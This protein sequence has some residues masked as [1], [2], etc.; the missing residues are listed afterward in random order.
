MTTILGIDP[1]AR[2]GTCLLM[3]ESRAHAPL[4]V[5]NREVYGGSDGFRQW[6]ADT[7]PYVGVDLIVCESF[8]LREGTHGVDLSPVEVIEALK[9]L[10]RDAGLKVLYSPPGGR[11]KRVPDRVMKRL[12][13]YLPGKQWR[14]AREAI[15]HSLA[16][17]KMDGNVAVLR[18]FE[19]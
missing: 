11:L 1:G 4:L 16:Y 5:W 10:A 8:T 14:N 6:W 18:A 19:E 3:A 7:K 17:F 9:G 2:T 12:G 13:M 15:R